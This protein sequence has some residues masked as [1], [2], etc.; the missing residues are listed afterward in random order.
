M[1]SEEERTDTASESHREDTHEDRDDH[2]SEHVEEPR[3]GTAK[4]RSDDNFVTTSQLLKGYFEKK[5]CSLKR[6]LVEDAESN[7]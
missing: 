1:A 5:F 4:D 3:A 6:D 7:S 2:E